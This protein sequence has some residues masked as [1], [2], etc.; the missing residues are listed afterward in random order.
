MTHYQINACIKCNTLNHFES[1]KKREWSKK[2][3]DYP[4]VTC[5][6]SVWDS[7]IFNK[8]S[9]EEYVPIITTFEKTRSKK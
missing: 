8:N 4:C 7:H 5:G 9:A 3:D 2:K 1:K 6:Y